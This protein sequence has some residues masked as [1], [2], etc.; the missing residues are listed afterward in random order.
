[1]ASWFIP[2]AFVYKSPGSFH[3]AKDI[4]DF[5]PSFLNALIAKKHNMLISLL[6]LLKTEV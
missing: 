5:P 1:V 4:G 2:Q 3:C 6:T